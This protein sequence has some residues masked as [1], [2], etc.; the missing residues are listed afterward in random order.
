MP[1]PEPT[2]APELTPAP[3]PT[4]APATSLPAVSV[5]MPILNEERHLE[6]AVAAVLGQDYA[7]PVEV[8]LALGPSRDRTDEIAAALA[9]ADPRVHTVPNPSG[10]TPE[11]L[12]AA[13]GASR[14]D[15]VVRVDGHGVLDRDYVRTAVELLEDTGA[16]NVGGLMDAEGVTTFERAVAAAMTSRLGV[17]ASRF[18]TGGEPGPADTVYLGVFRREWLDR[19]GGYDPRFVRAQDWELNHRIREAGGLVWFSPLLRV[20][21]RPRPTLATLARQ[22][23]DYGRWRRVVA[24]THSGTINARYLAPPLALAGV[25]LGAVAGLV[26]PP[27]W[28]VPLAYLALTTVGGLTIRAGIG[29][30][31]RV[32]LP[33]ILPTMHLSWGW[34]FISSRV[35]IEDA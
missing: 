25:V 33:V 17:G 32:L 11:A 22:Y 12:N 9:A 18:H 19:M 20:S 4:P 13:L 31:E 16:A 15:I 14:S 7:G 35:R 1:V 21:Y 34:G 28:L 24:R 6:E 2:S 5:V 23:R 27:A 8:V 30:G 3:E 29:W 10:R 26:W